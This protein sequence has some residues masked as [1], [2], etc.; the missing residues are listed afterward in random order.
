M[1]QA[2]LWNRHVAGICI[3]VERASCPFHFPANRMP[4]PQASWNGNRGGTGI[5]VEQALWWNGHLACFI[6]RASSN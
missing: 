3:F 5:V 1:E 6:F 2:S 4:T